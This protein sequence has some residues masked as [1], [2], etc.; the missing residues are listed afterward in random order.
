[1]KLNVYPTIFLPGSQVT[2]GFGWDPYTFPSRPR[3]HTAIDRAGPGVVRC[4]LEAE[5][6]VWIDD[7][8]EG[9]S[10]LRLFFSGG[11]LRLLHF[12]RGE[13]DSGALAA[14][15]SGAGL[16][17]G[18]PIGPAGNHGLSVKAKGGTGRHVHCSLVLEPGQYDGDLEARIGSIWHNDYSTDYR[19]RYG[20]PFVAQAKQR[21]IKWMN[22]HIIARFDPYYNGALRFYVNPA[23]YGL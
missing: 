7:D 12:I 6:S 2:T 1:M 13:L 9:C 15:L 14:G 17:L 10:V 20:Q 11:E 19:A 21:G 23:V 18:D 16:A 5:R 8:A 4:P 3:I 22:A